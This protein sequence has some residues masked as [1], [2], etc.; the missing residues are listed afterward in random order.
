MV[1]S[2]VPWKTSFSSYSIWD[3]LLLHHLLRFG[4]FFFSRREGG[5]TFPWANTSGKPLPTLLS[6]LLSSFVFT[7]ALCIYKYHICIYSSFRWWCRRPFGNRAALF[8]L[9]L[10]D[11]YFSHFDKCLI[12]WNDLLL[13]LDPL[14]FALRVL[15]INSTGTLHPLFFLSTKLVGGTFLNLC[16]PHIF[17]IRKNWF[18]PRQQLDHPRKKNGPNCFSDGLAMSRE[19]RCTLTDARSLKWNSK[20]RTYF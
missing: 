1:L 5:V 12:K 11:F 7:S 10:L 18:K 6:F 4:S 13:G 8:F 16:A 14:F 19:T 9:L 3:S 2:F 15:P 20:C 17:L